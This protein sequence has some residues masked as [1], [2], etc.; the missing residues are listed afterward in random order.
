MHRSTLSGYH[1]LLSSLLS[2][3]KYPLPFQHSNLQEGLLM[4]AQKWLVSL[5]SLRKLWLLYL[6]QWLTYSSTSPCQ[7]DWRAAFLPTSLD[8]TG[9]A[10]LQ[11]SRT[12]FCLKTHTWQINT[13]P[14]KVTFKIRIINIFLWPR[15]LLLGKSLQDNV[16]PRS[17]LL[18]RSC[19]HIDRFAIQKIAF[20]FKE[21]IQQAVMCSLKWRK[22]I[23]CASNPILSNLSCN[24]PR[25]REWWMRNNL[26]PR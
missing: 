15:F 5:S 6:C 7:Q 16:L 25:C 2:H 8:E 14:L 12:A 13:D 10:M 23:L 11:T 1:F 9:N 17:R 22:A 20:H 18:P 24:K 21:Y 26:L 19:F 3:G 4:L